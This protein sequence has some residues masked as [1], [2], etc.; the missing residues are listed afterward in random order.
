MQ[1][2]RTPFFFFLEVIKPQDDLQHRKGLLG[3]QTK[4]SRCSHQG[5]CG[6]PFRFI[7]RRKAQNQC[8]GCQAKIFAFCLV[9]F[10]P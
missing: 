1:E 6:K 8:P 5:V 7:S 2:L 9:R 10:L 3:L 4:G